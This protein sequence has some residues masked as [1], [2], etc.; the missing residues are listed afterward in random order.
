MPASSTIREVMQAI[1]RG[2]LGLALLV[3]AENNAF[4]GLATDG[5]IRRALLAG[6]GLESSVAGV[7][8]PVP[9]T[10]PAGTPSESLSEMF[11]APV[12]IIPLLDEQSRVVDLAIMDRRM[13]L[14]VAEPSFGEKELKYTA[15]CVLTGWVS[16]AGP[17]VTRFEE[18]FA[19]FCG[20]KHAIAASNGTT[21]LHLAMLALGIGPGDE[22]IVPTLTFIATANAVTYTGARPV[23]VDSEPET[24]NI[25]PAQIERA[26][27]PKTR[28]IIPVHLYGHPANM[29][30][31]LDIAQRYGLFVVEDAA[32]AHGARYQNRIVGNLGDIG[33]FS[34]YGNK[35]IT[36]GEGGMLVTDRTDLAERIRILRDHGMS[37]ERRYWHTH[38]GYNY[39]MTNI[40]AALGV[41]Q[42]ERID[43]I[44]A[45]KRQLARTYGA[46]LAGVTGLS[47]PPA[48]AWADNVYW[49]YSIQVQPER[50]GMRRDD[51]MAALQAMQI[52]TRPLFPPVHQQP[53]YATG[54]R[55]PVAEAL[56]QNGLSLP[57]SAALS[58]ADIARIISAIRTLAGSAPTQIQ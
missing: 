3:D 14:P 12:R 30:A 15:E 38:L 40:Q 54:Q 51:L 52:E 32:E 31:I 2:A 19:E 29:A 55:L 8:R 5:D 42:M 45:A 6:L 16:S 36:T 34:F 57:S 9:Q 22:V 35:I 7:P 50:F 11:S 39:R 21:A 46:G 4:V 17:F 37:P 56:S 48:A 28:A 58:P 53:I 18:M 23:F 44:L 43:A 27:T 33:I 1:D 47:L 20:A 25:D 41:A 26:I 24:W 10:A 13:R 49:L